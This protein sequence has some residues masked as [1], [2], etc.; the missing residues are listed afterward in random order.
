MNFPEYNMTSECLGLTLQENYKDRRL[1]GL[2]LKD[3]AS[4]FFNMDS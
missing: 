4:L 3:I 1:K 2:D